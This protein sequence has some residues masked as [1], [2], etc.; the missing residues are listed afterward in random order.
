MKHIDFVHLHVHSQYSLLDGMIRFPELCQQAS[1]YRM[2]AVA[3]T[4]HGNMFGAIEFYQQAYKY[5]VKPIIGCELYVAPGKLEDRNV[6][7]GIGES[8]RHLCVLAKNMQGYKNLMKLTTDGYLKGFYYRPRVDKDLLKKHHEGLIAMSACLHGEIP[9]LLLKGD[10]GGA[11]RAAEEYREIFGPGN[12][13]LEIME[14]GLPEQKIVNEGL[15]SLG[16]RLSLPLVAT[17]DC[18]YLK[19]EDA[20]AHDVLLCIQT[21]K[22]VEDKDRLRFRTDQFFFRSPEEM[23]ALFADTPQA[24]INTVEIAEKCNL[25]L[26]LGKVYLPRFPLE[27]DQS[28]DEVLA[29]MAWEGLR[30]RFSQIPIREES[31]KKK[32]EKRLQEELTIIRSMGFSG[33]FLIVA[34]FINYAKHKNIPVGPGRGSA[35][36]SLVAYAIG[37]TNI[38]PIRYGLFFERFLNPE[39]KSMPDIDTDFCQEGRDEIIR[40]VT[41]KYGEDKVAQIITFGKMQAKAV[42][43]DVGRALNIPYAEVDAIAKLVPGILNI[44]LE[45]ALEMEPRLKEEA[46]RSEK[47]KELLVLSRSLEGLARHSSTHAAGVVISDLPLVER[48]PLCRSPRNEIVT[49][50]SMNDLAAIGLTKFDFLGLKTL[51]MIKNVKEMVEKGRGVV[52]DLENIPLDDEPTYELLQKGDTDGVFQLESAG[53]K[54]ILINMKPDC[55]EDL[56]A[57]IALYRP[58]P[59]EMVP[60]FIAR[61]LGKTKISYIVQELEPIL[62]ETYGIILYQEQVMQ[63]ANTIGNYT[64]AQ[65]DDLRKSISK[66]IAEVMDKEKPRFLAGAKAN[67]ISTDKAEKIWEYMERFAKY[68]FNKSHSTAY[69]MISYQT[70]YLKAH[71]PLEFMA[72]LLTSEKD[73]RDKIIKYLTSCKE[74]GINVFPPDIN[75]SLKDFTVAGNSIRFGLEAVKNVGAGAAEAIIRAREELGGRFKSLEDFFLKVDLKKVNKRVLESL[76][77]CGA[78]DSLGYNRR[79]IALSYEQFM[80]LAQGMLKKRSADQIGMFDMFEDARRVVNERVPMPEVE[81]WDEKEK[82]AFEKELLGFYVTGH[83]LW[84]YRNQI[85]RFVTADSSN[86][87]EKKDRETVVI[88]G[89][90]GS[91]REMTTKKKELMGQLVLE[92]FM[93]SINVI[94]FPDV[95]RS[96]FSAVHS[97]EPIVVKGQV[98][99]EDEAVKVIASEVLPLRQ[100]LLSN[101]LGEEVHFYFDLADTT[102]EKLSHLKEILK[103]HKGEARTFLHLSSPAGEAVIFLGESYRTK[104]SEKL[105]SE[106]EGNFGTAA[107]QWK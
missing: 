11:I 51:T 95:Y 26:E 66:K 9:S 31:E 80:D 30:Q 5:G 22:T 28:A 29:S 85:A 78:F 52:L 57:L 55:I 107:V 48:V 97:E 49:Q 82:L 68:G 73:N 56:I 45:E 105:K 63:I 15:K 42:I 91:L 3:L 17:N 70:A 74:K 58:G 19:K 106:V 76:I 90:P 64:M 104:K 69:A 99:V 60:D 101:G 93:G 37:I 77:K 79:Q 23:K 36:G 8:A 2:P 12:F 41:N 32:Y 53:M 33:Y 20:S 24:I 35:A 46:A 39:R 14:N 62:K 83:P 72:A 54:D 50:Y 16:E 43:R 4:D 47:I 75:E 1:A 13:Y 18:H 87:G 94:L 88:V 25:I 40:Y 71:Y 59:M 7:G 98:S 84:Q 67:K 6:N 100:Y 34:D 102:E 92:D 96:G 10:F 61:K 86:I 89:L 81:D 38:D 65:A 21:G 27:K 103:R 44:T